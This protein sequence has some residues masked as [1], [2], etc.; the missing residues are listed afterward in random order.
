MDKIATW[1]EKDRDALFLDAAERLPE[2][3]PAL[4]EKD[5]WV[6]WLLRRLFL[7]DQDVSIIFLTGF[8]LV[9]W[10]GT[11]DQIATASWRPV[12]GCRPGR[13]QRGPLR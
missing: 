7:R 9:G 6:C 13:D 3:P 10:V 8:L 4:I 2:L 12:C 1:T 11:P 5:F